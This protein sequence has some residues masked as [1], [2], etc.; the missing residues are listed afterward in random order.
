MCIIT[1]CCVVK[2][3]YLEQ[4]EKLSM[5]FCS[6]IQSFNRNRCMFCQ[7]TKFVVQTKALILPTAVLLKF[8]SSPLT[9]NT[10]F[11]T[12]LT[13]NSSVCL[14]SNTTITLF[15]FDIYE[16][17]TIGYNKI[18]IHTLFFV[19]I[20]AEPYCN[21]LIVK[22]QFRNILTLSTTYSASSK[23]PTTTV[24]SCFGIST[25]ST[26]RET[27]ASVVSIVKTFFYDSNLH[28]VGYKHFQ[29]TYLGLRF[30]SSFYGL[31]LFYFSFSIPCCR[32]R[33]LHSI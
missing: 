25:G 8:I 27:E 3:N 29:E 17:I 16:Q 4:S 7:I 12:T 20:S 24:T 10:R 31:H 9:M 1:F 22:K 5:L 2:K 23:N 18:S 26:E 30:R 32:C 19:S 13:H 21:T 28:G 11:P 33:Q 14:A 6:D 15:H